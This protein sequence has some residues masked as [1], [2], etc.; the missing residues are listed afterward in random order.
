LRADGRSLGDGVSGVA[1]SSAAAQRFSPPAPLVA[2]QLANRRRLKALLSTRSDKYACRGTNVDR[3]RAYC[4]QLLHD[5]GSSGAHESHELAKQRITVAVTE[6]HLATISHITVQSCQ[7]EPDDVLAQC[8]QDMN[9][10]DSARNTYTLFSLELQGICQDVNHDFNRQREQQAIDAVLTATIQSAEAMKSMQSHTFDLA[11]ELAQ[12][13]RSSSSALQSD[14]LQHAA[15][16][17]A[18]FESL[19]TATDKLESGQDSILQGLASQT[20][21][22]HALLQDAEGVQRLINATSD[23]IARS[24]ADIIAMQKDA[25]ATAGQTKHELLALKETQ[26]AGFERALDSLTQ[27]QGLQEQMAE[28]QR[29]GLEAV[30]S[31]R[32]SQAAAFEAAAGQLTSLSQEQ[33][34]AFRRGEEQLVQLQSS[35][36]S[37]VTEQGSILASVQHSSEELRR[38]SQEQSQ[39]FLA[40]GASLASIRSQAAEAEAKLGAMV[41]ELQHVAQQLLGINVD[42]L[43]QLFRIESA[44]FYVAFAPVVYMLTATERT[45]GA[46]FWIFTLLLV[47]LLVELNLVSGAQRLHYVLTAAQFDALRAQLRYALSLVSLLTLALSALLHRDY[48]Q[49]NYSVA[50]KSAT[51]LKNNHRMLHE[52]LERTE[53]LSPRSSAAAAAAAAASHARKPSFKANPFQSRPPPS[54]DYDDD[55]EEQQVEGRPSP[56]QMRVVQS[57]R[58]AQR[59]GE[60][61]AVDSWRHIDVNACCADHQPPQGL[62]RFFP[63]TSSFASTSAST[64]TG[65][66]AAAA[67]TTSAGSTAAAAPLQKIPSLSPRAAAAAP[68][69]FTVPKAGGGGGQY[70]QHSRA[71][72]FSMG[73]RSTATTDSG[74]PSPRSATGLSSGRASPYHRGGG[75]HSDE[76]DDDASERSSFPGGGGED[77]E[78]ESHVSGSRR[79]RRSHSRSRS[80]ST[81]PDARVLAARKSATPARKSAGPRI[82]H[83][84]VA[85]EEDEDE[86]YD[87]GKEGQQHPRDKEPGASKA[88]ASIA[89]AAAAAASKPKHRTK[90]SM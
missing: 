30:D 83:H 82:V 54:L 75:E 37:I 20:A 1:L 60:D 61:T 89:T 77:S 55:E 41:G 31:L 59:F 5:D 19:K 32:S 11:A 28:A 3:L 21:H 56:A 80:A 22:L 63:S 66:N 14:L 74:L 67:D 51:I 81:T 49:L 64:S 87:E 52:L 13:V 2:Q 48:A 42:M 62:R 4:D 84:E 58:K 33:E 26:K 16:E 43:S 53:V 40:A 36:A 12:T 57:P 38:L 78:G 27:L 79:S 73:Q 85:D 69:H 34:K 15:A 39:S 9:R 65:G 44:F 71:A 23:D 18:R 70:A 35:Q 8:I 6:C 10:E 29:Q 45:A 68:A 50:E 17:Q 86:E 72:S 46:R 25:E 76:E 47:A 24:Q 88:S 7:D 90:A